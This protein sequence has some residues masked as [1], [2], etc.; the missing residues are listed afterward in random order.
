MVFRLQRRTCGRESTVSYTIG[1]DIETI[2][3]ILVDNPEARDDDFMLY[4]FFLE[5][6]GYDTTRL[7]VFDLLIR[8]ED[9]TIQNLDNVKRLRR[10]LQ[11]QHP[12]LRGQR[13]HDRH[14]RMIAAKKE[15]HAIETGIDE[16]V[17]PGKPLEPGTLF[18]QE[19]Q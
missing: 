18:N 6:K 5:E 2:R 13:W 4:N 19:V 12:E 3:R 7:A 9:G 11:E 14:R 16:K 17:R 1:S 15:I 8:N 10:E